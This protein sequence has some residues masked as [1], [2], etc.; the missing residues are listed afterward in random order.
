MGF[1]DRF[2]KAPVDRPISIADLVPPRPRRTPRHDFSCVC[3]DCQKGK[4]TASCPCDWRGSVRK[5]AYD[6]PKHG[7]ATEPK[8]LKILDTYKEPE[9]LFDTAP[10]LYKVGDVLEQG[11]VEAMNWDSNYPW[12]VTEVVERVYGAFS[13]ATPSLPVDMVRAQIIQDEPTDD[14]LGDLIAT[15]A[16]MDA[17]LAD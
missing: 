3:F 11:V 5:S 1:L 6:C 7:P 10:G 14:E 13:M 4:T 9:Y 17:A 15:L 2:K 16:G 8:G 12:V